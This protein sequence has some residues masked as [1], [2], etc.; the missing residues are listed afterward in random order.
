MLWGRLQETAYTC[1]GGVATNVHNEHSWT[2]EKR[3]CSRSRLCGGLA[4]LYSQRKIL[5]I[6]QGLVDLIDEEEMSEARRMQGRG[7]E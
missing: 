2:D 4:T 5:L 1:T 7:E 6:T 3:W